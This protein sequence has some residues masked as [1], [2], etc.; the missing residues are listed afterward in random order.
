MWFLLLTLQETDF[1]ELMESVRDGGLSLSL[2]VALS[3]L[4]DTHGAD[5][6]SGVL[7]EL[8]E[9]A[10]RDALGC[11]RLL[12]SIQRAEDLSVMGLTMRPSSWRARFV[13]ARYL[14]FPS[15]SYM[16]WSLGLA[17]G[18]ALGWLGR[19]A[20]TWPRHAQRR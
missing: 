13:L 5:V 1:D 16:R 10:R 19:M 20:P 17:E 11:E 8:G 9:R 2:L 3:Y 6:P 14:L 15:A 7:A 12:R 18:P 4:A